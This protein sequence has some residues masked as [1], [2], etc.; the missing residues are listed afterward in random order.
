MSSVDHHIGIVPACTD[1]TVQPTART[2]TS[3]EIVC[4]DLER[5]KQGYHMYTPSFRQG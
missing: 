2:M 4:R 1:C 5:A 3:E